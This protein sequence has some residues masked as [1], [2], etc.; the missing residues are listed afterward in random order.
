MFINPVDHRL[1]DK[2]LTHLSFESV[3]IQRTSSGEQVTGNLHAGHPGSG[4]L[5]IKVSFFMH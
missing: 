1:K 5:A 2:V 4:T 3:V